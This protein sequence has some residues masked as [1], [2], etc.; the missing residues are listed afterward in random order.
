MARMRKPTRRASRTAPQ[1]AEERA[2]VALAT[3][4]SERQLSQW[5]VARIIGV[6]CQ[7]VVSAMERGRCWSLSKLQALATAGLVD[8]DDIFEAQ[9]PDHGQ[10]AA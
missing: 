7:T 5:D 2:G 8:V 9:H 6:K 4:R 3:A 1:T 10:G